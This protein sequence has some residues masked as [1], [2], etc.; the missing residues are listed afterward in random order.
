MLFGIY[1][2]NANIA[3]IVATFKGPA[4]KVCPA[5]GGTEPVIAYA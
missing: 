2:N 4:K 1:K 5:H 3:K